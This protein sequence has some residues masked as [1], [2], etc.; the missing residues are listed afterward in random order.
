MSQQ[1][2]LGC[3]SPS[4]LPYQGDLWSGNIA[5]VE[6]QPAIFDPATYY[7][8]HEAEWGMSWCALPVRCPQ[9]SRTSR[10]LRACPVPLTQLCRQPPLEAMHQL[11]WLATRMHSPTA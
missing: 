5:A 2:H 3:A 1:S 10:A 6:G 8:H 11:P 4:P 9:H 7:G